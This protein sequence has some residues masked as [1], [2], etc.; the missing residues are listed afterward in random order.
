[1]SGVTVMAGRRPAAHPDSAGALI[2]DAAKR[3]AAAGI[4]SARL[5]A[6]LL[7]AEAF[8]VD[9]AWLIAHPD[10][11]PT[12]ARRRRFRALVA[13]RERR[14]PVAL[15]LGRREF[16]G[17]AF[18]LG[19]ATLVPRPETETVVA[20]AL[21]AVADRGG[22]L[23]ILDL[24]TGSGCLLL[25][26]LSELADARGL[27]VDVSPAAL[28]VARANARRLGLGGRA[29]F[30]KSDWADAVADAFDLVVANPPYVA[31]GDLDRLA[32]EVSRF[33]PRLALAGGADG[34]AAYRRLIPGLAGRLKAG[35]RVV[36]EIGATQADAVASMLEDHGLRVSGVHGDLAGRPRAIS[37][38]AE[39]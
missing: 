7:A 28:T 39:F 23:D 26:L 17:L 15:I 8:G 22:K 29:R 13:R 32:P 34:L 9:A 33:E 36:L 11:R 16:W 35:A 10:D 24:G 38:R 20:E 37:A 25:A 19:K 4:D 18:R 6:R 12:P 2:A 14:E 31:D 21:A 1:M 3:F 5:D 27:G 30:R